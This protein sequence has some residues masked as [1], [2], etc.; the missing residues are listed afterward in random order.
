MSDMANDNLIKTLIFAA[1]ISLNNIIWYNIL[2]LGFL[3]CEAI[4]VGILIL[5][6]WK[7]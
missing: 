7:K 6:L 5:L 2:G 1:L 3:L 4:I